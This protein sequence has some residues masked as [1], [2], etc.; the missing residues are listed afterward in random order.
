MANEESNPYRIVIGGL[1]GSL[2]T[3]LVERR[4]QEELG[5]VQVLDWK[6][7]NDFKVIGSRTG[8]TCPCGKSLR[9]YTTGRVL[10]IALHYTK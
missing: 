6:V 1:V 3:E 4:A 8:F 7:E 9:D 10:T 2:S 5:D